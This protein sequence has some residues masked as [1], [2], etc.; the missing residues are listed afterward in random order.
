MYLH[1]LQIPKKVLT[2]NS[3]N[4]ICFQHF[5][6]HLKTPSR[7][8]QDVLEFLR[9]IVTKTDKRFVISLDLGYFLHHCHAKISLN[10]YASTVAYIY[11]KYM[12]TVVY[13]YYIHR[14]SGD[15]EL[16]SS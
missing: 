15:N 8:L 10:I 11:E 4:F 14:L 3:V 16:P 7:C 6:R 5:K 2:R 1:V 9:L 13:T 12:Q